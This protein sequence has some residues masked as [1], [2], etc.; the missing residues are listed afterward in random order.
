MTSSAITTRPK[1]S[2]RLKRKSKRKDKRAGE[3]EFVCTLQFMNKLPDLP[4]DPKFLKCPLDENR[5]IVYRPTTLERDFKFEMLTGIDVGVTL[6]LIDLSS[7]VV[8][9]HPPPMDPIDQQLLD[10]ASKANAKSHPPTV[11]FLL[12]PQ[13]LAT[14]LADARVPSVANFV[15][16]NKDDLNPPEEDRS[17]QIL[18]INGSFEAARVTPKHP[19]NPKLQPVEIFQLLP[20]EDLWGNEY[21]EVVFDTDPVPED[22]EQSSRKRKNAVIK[23]VSVPGQDITCLRYFTPKRRRLNDDDDMEDEPDENETEYEWVREYKYRLHKGEGDNFLFVMKD[24]EM[25]YHEIRTKVLMQKVTNE[26]QLSK[27]SRVVL[28]KLPVL[29]ASAQQ[30]LEN[31]RQMIQDDESRASVFKWVRARAEQNG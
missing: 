19:T 21:S 5:H 23:S 26:V 4:Y 9:E 14:D 6:D 15:K 29:S 24:K 30:Q 27:P 18:N 16:E 31:A 8:P 20:D 11:S 13:Y 10:G 7:F 17:K 28:R 1:L 12:H 3:S 22:D 25:T 2:E